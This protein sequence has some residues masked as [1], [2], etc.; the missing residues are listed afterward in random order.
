MAARRKKIIK[1]T[2]SEFMSWLEGVESMQ[3]EDW[4]PTLDQWQTIRKLLDN[5]QPD[6]E[7]E[8]VKEQIA[9][10]VATVMQA[11]MG[12][13]QMGMAPVQS[14]FEAPA[15]VP[16]PVIP[17]RLKPSALQEAPPVAPGVPAATVTKKDQ[18]LDTSDGNYESEFM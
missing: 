9:T 13:P 4:A 18:V 10:P 5:L 8:I 3:E 14:A 11:P 6:V 12:Q 7:T 16:A 1:K 17:Q 2:Y 15:P